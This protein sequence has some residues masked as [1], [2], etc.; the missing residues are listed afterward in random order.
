M[1]TT[2]WRRLSTRLKRAGV[3]TLG[4]GAMGGKGEGGAGV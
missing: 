3:N 2:T 4:G 1:S